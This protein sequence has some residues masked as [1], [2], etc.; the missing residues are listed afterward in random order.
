MSAWQTTIPAPQVY[1]VMSWGDYSKNKGLSATAHEAIGQ[2][3][4]MVKGQ[5]G[6]RGVSPRRSGAHCRGSGA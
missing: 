4:F 2:V 6:K 3:V 5:R 1:D